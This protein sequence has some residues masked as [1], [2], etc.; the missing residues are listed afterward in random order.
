VWRA[1]GPDAAVLDSALQTA[2]VEA[3]HGLLELFGYTATPLITIT[4]TA[5]G[6]TNVT[7]ADAS[8]GTGARHRLADTLSFILGLTST[9]VL[10]AGSVS[11]SESASG[12][13]L[14][15]D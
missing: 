12:F 7:G 4:A 5:P 13:A 15:E 10:Q 14:G 8:V 3:V 11:G 1:Y 9:H 2:L 6:G